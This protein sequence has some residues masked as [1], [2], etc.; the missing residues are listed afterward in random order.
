MMVSYGI[1]TVLPNIEYDCDCNEIDCYS[2][3]EYE[4]C[5]ETYQ[6]AQESNSRTF[7]I[8]ALIIATIAFTTSFFV[9]LQNHLVLSSIFTILVASLQYWEFAGDI[10]K[11]LLSAISLAI[12]AYYLN[13]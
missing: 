13:K 8:V 12:L 3:E 4:L 9:P 2:S 6:S 10:I 11:F 1:N 5:D 7:F